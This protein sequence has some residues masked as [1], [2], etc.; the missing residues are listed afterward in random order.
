MIKVSELREQIF[1]D[2]KKI[3][4]RIILERVS[5]IVDLS[6]RAFNDEEYLTLT[7][8]E[9]KR[10]MIIHDI[11]RVNNPQYLDVIA[12]FVKKF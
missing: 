8:D 1:K 5:K 2:S 4:S 6:Q 10:I 11:L 7:E 12:C 3:K 9:R